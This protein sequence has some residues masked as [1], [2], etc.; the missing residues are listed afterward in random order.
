VKIWLSC[1]GGSAQYVPGEGRRAEIEA[2]GS[3]TVLALLALIGVSSDLF[4]F[5]LLN[6]SRVDL[7]HEIGEGDDVVLVSAIS[8]G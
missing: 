3:K 7:T 1:V 2:G 8:G 6:G 5:A 4:M